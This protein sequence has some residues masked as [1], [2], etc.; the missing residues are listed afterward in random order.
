VQ[1]SLALAALLLLPF[2]GASGTRVVAGGTARRILAS[3]TLGVQALLA[4]T[5]LVGA[6]PT[7]G[8]LLQMPW[9]RPLGLE[10]AFRADPIALSFALAVLMASAWLLWTEPGRGDG[11]PQGQRRT[12]SVLC[13]AGC[14]Q[15]MVLADNLLLLAASAFLASAATF[16]LERT[17]P[18]HDGDGAAFDLIAATAGALALLAAALL[19]ADAAGNTSLGALPAALAASRATPLGSL[20]LALLAF[21]AS[22]RAARWPWA[23]AA[24]RSGA[25]T[26]RGGAVALLGGT[27]LALR[28]LPLLDSNLLRVA[29]LAGLPAMALLLAGLARAIRPAPAP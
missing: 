20:T 10:L 22:T 21:G 9:V 6:T 15:A 12:V 7:T 23:P 26:G 4:L 19:V 17:D 1:V 13:V 14:V 18:A 29:L 24:D 25:A 3:L 28:L 27:Y 16:T 2:A 5:L 11:G 8:A